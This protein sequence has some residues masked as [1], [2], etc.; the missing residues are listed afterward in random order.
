MTLL[1]ISQISQL[2]TIQDT[3]LILVTKPSSNFTI[4][5]GDFKKCLPQITKTTLGLDKVANLSPLEL[6][7]SDA[8]LAALDKKSDKGHTHQIPDVTGLAET[9][10]DK[11]DKNHGHS[12][13]DVAGLLD[14]LTLIKRKLSELSLVND[15]TLR[16][17]LD[18]LSQSFQ[19]IVR[20]V[21][22]LENLPKASYNINEITGLV[23]ALADKAD[24]QSVTN[25]TDLVTN[26][27]NSL[28][29]FT[30]GIDRVVGLATAL[31][32]FALKSHLHLASQIQDFE[33]AV[34]T[35]LTNNPHK[36]AIG[37]VNGLSL[38]LDGKANQDFV[39]NSLAD[40]ADKSMIT[41][42]ASNLDAW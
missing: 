1:K 23:Q 11:A 3:D 41:V 36:H 10:A 17:D 19:S 32:S 34:L 30:I 24:K 14:E 7:L 25:L 9:L 5:F 13:S 15:S 20:R 2:P 33:S 18:S 31:D 8:A 42:T 37:D 27:Q 22:T 38:A 39:V 12:I 4:K 21:S 16:T 40:K 29:T 35:V 28:S 6:P 26:L